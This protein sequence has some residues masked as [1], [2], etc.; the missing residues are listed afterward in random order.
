[1]KPNS[2]KGYTIGDPLLP[3]TTKYPWRL[4]DEEL[5]YPFYE[6]AVKAGIT[7]VCIH[8]GLMPKDYETSIPGGAWQYANVDDL[9][10]GGEGL[11]ADQFRDLPFRASRIPRGPDSEL[12]EFEK[13]GYIR[14]VSPISPQSR[15]NS[16][17]ATSTAISARRSR[18]RRSPIRA[19][20]PR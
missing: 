17:S 8:K 3:Q 7:T 2:W 12:A 20:A 9:A 18:S 15:R 16:A 1:M 6:K 14:W 11:A 13:T 4:D 5:M 19:S 10:E